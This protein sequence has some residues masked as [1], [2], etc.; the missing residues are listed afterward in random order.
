MKSKII[1]C[2]I[3]KIK[4]NLS[5]F[6][7]HFV[8]FPVAGKQTAPLST[9]HFHAA[10]IPC[11]SPRTPCPLMMRLLCVRRCAKMELIKIKRW[12][13]CSNLFMAR[14]ITLDVKHK[15]PTTHPERIPGG[16]KRKYLFILCDSRSWFCMRR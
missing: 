11:K 5:C 2:F 9:P 1:H 15:S 3:F 6:K 8:C 7:R 13:D 16:H 12:P 14:E 10:Q 4:S